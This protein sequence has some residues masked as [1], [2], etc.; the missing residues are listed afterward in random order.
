[1]TE[2][3][4]TD[5]EDDPAGSS[6]KGGPI[7]IEDV[8]L[9]CNGTCRCGGATGANVHVAPR[10][11]KLKLKMGPSAPAP[12]PTFDAA[13]LP[14]LPV[15]STSAHPYSFE[16]K[17]PAARPRAGSSSAE[18]DYAPKKKQRTNSFATGSR[19]GKATAL[20]A[21]SIRKRT[22]P[23]EKEVT[24]VAATSA[25]PT[26]LA[27]A[28]P[29]GVAAPSTIR[30]SVKPSHKKCE[31][32]HSYSASGS[33]T[34]LTRAAAPSR[35]SLRQ[36]LAMSVREASQSANNSDNDDTEQADKTIIADVTKERM[37]DV[38]DLDL[39]DSDD[40]SIEKAEEEALRAEFERSKGK[41]V[42]VSDSEELTDLEDEAEVG[43]DGWETNAKE[44]HRLHAS[45]NTIAVK[46]DDV[47]FDDDPNLAVTDLPPTGGLGVVTWSDYDSVDMD[48]D[49]NE[50][51]SHIAHD[52]EEELEEL[53]AI[54]EAVVGPVRDD[55]L[56]LGE[57]WFEEMSDMGDDES[58]S[59][60]D[61]ESEDGDTSDDD[62]E[63]D[64]G[65]K[66]KLVADGGWGFQTRSLSGSSAG[67]SASEMYF[68]GGE[69]TDSIDSDDMNRFGL[70][71]PEDEDTDSACSETDYYRDAPGTASLADVQ[72]PTTADL[73]SLPQ[74]LF[75]DEARMVELGA[76]DADPEKALRAAAEELEIAIQRRKAAARA[77]TSPV[78]PP[79]VKGKGKMRDI[80]EEDE[81]GTGTDGETGGRTPA[82][83]T[84]SKKAS[85]RSQD[86]NVVVIDGSDTFAP[87]PF[88]KVKKS[89]KRAGPLVSSRTLFAR[90]RP[91]PL[92]PSLFQLEGTPS[93]RVRAESKVSTTSVTDGSISGEVAEASPVLVPATL[94]FE[95]DDVLNESILED[96]PS[97]TSSDSD[98]EV[99]N[100]LQNDGT[101]PKPTE[102][103]KKVSA[104]SD[105]SRWSRI[106]IGAFRSS[107]MPSRPAPHF[108]ATIDASGRRSK[109]KGASSVFLPAAS[110]AL[111]G[112]KAVTSLNH[113][114]S[115]PG[116]NSST[117]KRAIERRMLTS[118][119]FG[120]VVTQGGSV[121]PLPSAVNAAAS[122]T[123]VEKRKGR[124]KDRKTPSGS[125]PAS[126]RSRQRS[127]SIASVAAAASLRIPP[128]GVSPFSAVG[129]PALP[130]Y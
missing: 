122:S 103:P 98:A 118:P 34:S 2:A 26:S 49:D 39:L 127:A 73:A 24:P 114:L 77:N 112:S 5:E 102:S 6:R 51:T 70:E 124:K 62:D 30:K 11:L 72:A 44:M 86:F 18:D 43:A 78:R 23:N 104:L 93:R 90:T 117:T 9:V 97:S 65:E 1:M 105:L 126:P 82:M 46:S 80:V 8:C 119:V 45:T 123:A 50:E 59:A 100:G 130:L 99:A 89:K 58:G 35:M 32:S 38:S 129:L 55:E 15:A 69:T 85:G 107:T 63:D 17:A 76:I 3:E 12:A 94:D 37:S 113:T 79:I 128:S 28:L 14:P 92:M 40:E 33:T 21:A 20:P 56:E 111:R 36:V 75:P 60:A 84:F 31:P 29:T 54:S 67:D 121:P 74:Y 27:A 41:A 66:M 68:S 91:F 71:A 101:T 115:S 57:L 106:P 108:S 13:S 47:S 4:S 42:F 10:G 52:F 61:D 110:A 22:R 16:P 25:A 53:L 88:S 81:A 83:G 48:D 95:L 7:V 109:D 19:K 116:M 120:P 87:S 64:D 125:R 96:D